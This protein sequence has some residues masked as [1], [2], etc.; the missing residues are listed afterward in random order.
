MAIQD[1]GVR[2]RVAQDFAAE[3]AQV[4]VN[5]G[6]GGHRV[7]F[8]EGEEILP[9]AGRVGDVDIHKPAVIQRR[10]RDHGRERAARVQAL[11]HRIAA[12]FQRQDAD[13]GVFHGQ[14]FEH[15]LPQQVTGSWNRL[16]A[17]DAPARQSRR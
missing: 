15:T 17:R 12:L 13:I 5:S 3:I 10:Q 2:A 8:A 7:A 6:H 16:G 9:A 14:E 1:A 11:I 4:G